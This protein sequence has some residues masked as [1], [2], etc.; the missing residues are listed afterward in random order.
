MI[1]PSTGLRIKYSSDW[2]TSFS[3]QEKKEMDKRIT[4]TRYLD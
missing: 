3:L 1:S 2:E 4:G